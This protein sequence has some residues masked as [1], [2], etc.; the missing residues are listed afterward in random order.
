MQHGETLNVLKGHDGSVTS[1]TLSSDEDWLAV[2]TSGGSV[3]LWTM[4]DRHHIVNEFEGSKRSKIGF[5]V[6]K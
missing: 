4:L 1:I 5:S 2:G 3:Y 6:W